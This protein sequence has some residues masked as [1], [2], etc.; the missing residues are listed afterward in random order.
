MTS[1]YLY[2]QVSL[3]IF[4]NNDYTYCHLSL[5]RSQQMA[6]AKVIQNMKKHMM[7]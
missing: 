4:C 7:K 3:G 5:R 1:K 2:L 6:T